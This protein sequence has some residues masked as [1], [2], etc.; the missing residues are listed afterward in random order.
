MTDKDQKE[1]QPPKEQGNKPLSGLSDQIIRWNFT[2]LV[3]L[4]RSG[5]R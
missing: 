1:T 5:T 4:R 3:F 2:L